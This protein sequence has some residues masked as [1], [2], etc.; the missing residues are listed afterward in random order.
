MLDQIEYLGI[1]GVEDLRQVF[2]P[3]YGFL[4][5]VLA[6]EPTGRGTLLASKCCVLI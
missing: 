3:P 4:G 2:P 6:P 1:D 5:L